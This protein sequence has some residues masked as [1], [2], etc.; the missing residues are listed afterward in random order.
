MYFYEGD[1]IKYISTYE[2]NKQEGIGT[3]NL[4]NARLGSIRLN[5]KSDQPQQDTDTDEDEERE[6][7]QEKTQQEKK[8]PP[9]IRTKEQK[10]RIKERQMAYYQTNKQIL[11]EKRKQSTASNRTKKGRYCISCDSLHVTP[12][13][14]IRH[15]NTSKHRKQI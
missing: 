3:D 4:D 7:E 14:F 9:R 6:E 12:S 13:A 1:D 15:T 11:D 5:S 10:E 8:R 2:L